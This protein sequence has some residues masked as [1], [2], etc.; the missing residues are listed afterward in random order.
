MVTNDQKSHFKK[1]NRF[2]VILILVISVIFTLQGL[3]LEGISYARL[4]LAATGS[5]FALSALVFFIKIPDTIKNNIILIFPL[6]AA[7]SLSH[8]RGGDS[9]M[10]IVY[11]LAIVL[12]T[13]Y[14]NK[15]VLIINVGILF[16][17]LI[18]LFVVTPESLLGQ[19][20][21]LR[22]FIIRLGMLLTIAIS[23]YFVTKWGNDYIQ[24]AK[25]SQ[26]LSDKAFSKL[27]AS[28][29]NIQKAIHVLD[30]ETNKTKSDIEQVVSNSNALSHAITEI[31]SGIDEQ[32]TRTD[33]VSNQIEKASH[34]LDKM[35]KIETSMTELTQKNLENLNQNQVNLDAFSEQMTLIA[36]VVA[37]SAETVMLLNTHIK[38]IT[39]A[40]QSIEQISQQTNMLALNASIEAARAGES[41][42]GFSV[43]ATEVGKLAEE[44]NRSSQ[45]IQT[46]LDDLTLSSNEA[47]EK[48]NSGNDAVQTGNTLIKTLNSDF[49]HMQSTFDN[50]QGNIKDLSKG[51][52]YFNSDF[53]IVQNELSEM[54]KIAS[55]HVASIEEILSNTE[56]QENSLLKIK[57][58]T[59]TIAKLSTNLNN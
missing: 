25:E 48:I 12:S 18:F 46:I 13:L 34:L 14:F 41:G 44:T 23:S 21:E 35:V 53:K 27:E 30:Y 33:T 20:Y 26:N 51:M 15:K 55:S 2:I 4:V 59:D 10:F 42:R 16:S 58:S 37:S 31:S 47:L 5:A 6:I 32:S 8:I 19:N 43:V 39:E 29:D 36:E 56:T 28:M 11:A 52:G 3:L 7:T 24:E 38:K 22:D 1:A 54:N 45:Y 49:D 57:E 50:L 17:T 40:I 9:R